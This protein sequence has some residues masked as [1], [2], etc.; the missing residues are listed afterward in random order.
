MIFLSVII[1]GAVGFLIYKASELFDEPK[2]LGI[3]KAGLGGLLVVFIATLAPK[4][5]FFLGPVLTLIVFTMMGYVLYWWRQNGSNFKEM[6][7]FV[8]IDLFLM[9]LAN[10]AIVRT[11]GVIKIQWVNG[12]IE[13]IPQVFFLMSIGYFVANM[14]WFHERL[15]RMKGGKKK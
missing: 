7:I 2:S 6:I 3:K 5:P 11:H 8:L 13:S 14:I 10:A 9:L 4:V 1:G 15:E 12:L